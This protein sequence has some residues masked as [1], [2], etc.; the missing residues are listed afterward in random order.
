MNRETRVR[1]WL[2]SQLLSEPTM[3]VDVA[4]NIGPQ[5]SLAEGRGIAY[6]LAYAEAVEPIGSTAQPVAETFDWDCEAWGD[7]WS[8]VALATTADAIDTALAG[9]SGIV[10]GVA[11]TCQARAA[12]VAPEDVNGQR[13][14][15][16]LGRRYRTF[17]VGP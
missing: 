8:D 4:G 2:I 13:V 1:R 16:R 3:P 11:I 15:Q 12:I 10:D 17:A 7:G 9:Q 6:S 5:G 14:A